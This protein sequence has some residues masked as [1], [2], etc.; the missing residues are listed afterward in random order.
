MQQPRTP[1]TWVITQFLADQ[2]PTLTIRQRKSFAMD[3][4]RSNSA[5]PPLSMNLRIVLSLMMFLQL[6]FGARG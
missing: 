1:D 6:R 4:Y 2:I 5:A 3:P